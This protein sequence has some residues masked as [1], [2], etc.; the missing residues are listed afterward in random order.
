MVYKQVDK[1]NIT[2]ASNGSLMRCTPIAV[3]G[4]NLS[5]KDLKRAS[6]ADVNFTHSQNLVKEAIF[7]YQLGIKYLLNN[8]KEKDRARNAFEYARKAARDF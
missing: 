8:P 3:W 1:H 6:E 4:C 7:A 5:D 2:S